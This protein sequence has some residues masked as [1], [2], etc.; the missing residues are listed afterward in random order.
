MIT[1]QSVANCS[2]SRGPVGAGLGR[3]SGYRPYI[4][5]PFRC[6]RT[7]RSISASTVK[8]HLIHGLG[9]TVR[10]GWEGEAPAEPLAPPARPEP[11]PPDSDNFSEP[12]YQDDLQ[13]RDPL[14]V[15]QEHRR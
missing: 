2:S 6:L 11:R 1:M 10:S 4:G 7:W 3:F 8:A 5:R 14:G 15:L 13:T 12:V 9:E